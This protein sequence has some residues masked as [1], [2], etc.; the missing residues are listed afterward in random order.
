MY[1]F[2]KFWVFLFV[3]C[4]CDKDKKKILK[5]FNEILLNYAKKRN[6]EFSNKIKINFT[7][8]N[9][10]SFYS[11]EDISINE[12]ILKVPLKSILTAELIKNNSPEFLLNIYSDMKNKSSPSNKI[13]RTKTVRE[14]V[15]ISLN[16][17]YAITHKKKSKIYK[18]FKPYFQTFENNLDYFPL[19]YGEGELNILN[20]TDFG[21]K[22]IQGKITMNEEFKYINKNYSYESIIFD[23]Y[24]KYRVLTVSKSYNLNGNSSLV[25]FADFF[26]LEFNKEL[27]NV[28]WEFDNKTNFF[29]IKATRDIK[30]GEILKMK[31]FTSP[32]SRYLLFYGITFENNSYIEPYNIKYLHHKLKN[33]MQYNNTFLNPNLDSFDLSKES[34]IGDTM[35]EY[36]NMGIFFNMPNTDDTGY[37]LMLKNL[38]YYME[39][40]NIISESDYYK[41][42]ILDTN[43]INIKRIVDLEK[44][45]LQNRIRLL[46]EIVEDRMKNKKKTDL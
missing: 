9:Y 24:I 44:L 38:K 3:F 34:F 17:E 37:I 31:I 43:R 36:R 14:Q 33:E 10:K 46:Q 1:Y 16:L 39:E 26:P 19:L 2:F 32:N 40:Y 22:V 29:I 20:Y 28:I 21:S 15:F 6:I 30:K 35:E 4:Y 12:T 45:L 41:K 7:S 25:P 8:I 23:D 13:F 5:P 27:Y 11:I 42:I 18:L